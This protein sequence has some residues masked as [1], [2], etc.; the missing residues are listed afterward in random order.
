LALKFTH[1]AASW[2][3]DDEFAKVIVATL[4]EHRNYMFPLAS[5]N[6]WHC[7]RDAVTF[8]QYQRETGNIV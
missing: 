8:E 1:F 2:I 6:N 7:L 4:V 3:D 5:P